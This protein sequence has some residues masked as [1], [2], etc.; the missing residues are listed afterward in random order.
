MPSELQTSERESEQ[1]AIV[2]III[3]AITEATTKTTTSLSTTTTTAAA[4]KQS[5]N[6]TSTNATTHCPKP[7]FG[8]ILKYSTSVPWEFV[9]TTEICTE[10]VFREITKITTTTTFVTIIIWKY[11]L[12]KTANVALNEKNVKSL[13]PDLRTN[14]LQNYFYK[15]GFLSVS[16]YTLN[17]LCHLSFKVE[18]IEI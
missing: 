16:M 17:F 10:M 1:S 13:G 8:N 11:N 18:R 6:L 5:C 2:A 12:I 15:L 3:T 7:R 9:I 4:T 14:W